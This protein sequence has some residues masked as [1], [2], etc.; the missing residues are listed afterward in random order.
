MSRLTLV[1]VPLVLCLAAPLQAQQAPTKISESTVRTAES[2]TPQF[3]SLTPREA[4]EL[5]GDIYMARK[6]YPAAIT[7]Y[8]QVLAA[9]SKNAAILNKVGIAY[10]QL[11]DLQLSERFYKRAIHADK[12]FASAVNNWGTVEYDKKH[13]GKAIS[14]YTKA[15]DLRGD[16]PTLYSNLGYA[17]FANKEYPQ[18]MNAFEKGLALDPTLFE[19]KGQGGTIVQQRTTTDPGLFYFLVAKTYARAGDA[20]RAA[21]YLKLARDDGYTEFLS[22]QT[23]PAFSKVI[24]NPAVQ[25]VLHE[26]PSY[27]SSQKKQIQN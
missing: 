3:S 4:A 6:E 17:Y 14:L 22:A 2:A 5:H 11:G 27:A 9:E 23:D 15:L 18:A 20:E 16:M 25:E 12:N 24:K 10:Q 26:A 7:A 1:A 8:Q 13:Y 21:H 19:H